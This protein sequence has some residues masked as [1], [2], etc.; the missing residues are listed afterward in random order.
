MFFIRFFGTFN[1]KL[2][3]FL[4]S[5][6][7]TYQM[8]KMLSCHQTFFLSLIVGCFLLSATSLMYAQG[9]SDAGFCTMGALR[10]NQPSSTE[11]NLRLKSIE[12]S[13]YV[14]QVNPKDYVTSFTIDA[15]IGI[16]KRSALQMKLPYIVMYGALANTQGLSDITLSFS[17]ALLQTQ[18]NNTLALTVG[19]KI[20][21]NRSD[22]R[23][24]D[25][26]PLPM[27]YQTS[28]GTYDGAIGI[29]YST[30]KWL[31]A[32]GWQVPILHDNNNQFLWGAWNS[33][34][35]S[36]IAAEYPRG[37][38]LK[39]G[40]DIMIRI[41]R[42]FRFSRFNF[43]IGVLPIYRITSDK[44]TLNGVETSFKDRNNN[45]NSKGLALTFLYGA[46][47]RFSVNSGIKG[48]LGVQNYTRDGH[49]DGLSRE[50]VASIGY[51]YRF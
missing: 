51:E 16:G 22:K 14:G 3:D 9:C 11:A 33:S 24:I 41:E 25:N 42:N 47:Y 39:R 32:T 23:S 44:I 31:L 1:R 49:P 12:L 21:T 8:S 36:A 18:K 20:P 50:Y 46:G 43:Y 29:S 35:D 26:R 38:Q 15:N 37:N 17:R 30:S 34:P 40:Q 10:P 6:L 5:N 19:A 45:F 13:Y 4:F 27:Y 2:I 28:L 48:F 7:L